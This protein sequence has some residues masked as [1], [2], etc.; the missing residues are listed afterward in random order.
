MQRLTL[1]MVAISGVLALSVSPDSRG[2]GGR[3]RL[4]ETASVRTSSQ[5]PDILVESVP[6]GAFI[7]VNQTVYG[8]TPCKIPIR[9]A[10]NSHTAFIVITALPTT[11]HQYLQ[12]RVFAEGEAIP[13]H[14]R[15]DMRLSP[16][17]P[18]LDVYYN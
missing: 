9:M 11:F 3:V 12:R 5:S 16:P 14:L 1:A 15:F 13:S 18:A 10:A 2:D 7:K 17:N 8:R 4:Q 6:S